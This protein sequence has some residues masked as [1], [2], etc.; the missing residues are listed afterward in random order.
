[1]TTHRRDWKECDLCRT[2]LDEHI[3]L[4]DL[5]FEPRNDG[6]SITMCPTVYERGRSA[7]T[8]DL[9]PVCWEKP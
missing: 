4:P 6:L 5:R 7:R 8:I 9:C 2:E 1:M 3:G